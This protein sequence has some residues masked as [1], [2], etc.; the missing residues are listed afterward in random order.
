MIECSK[1][2]IEKPESEFYYDKSRNR[3]IKK[4]KKCHKVN[5]K[6]KINQGIVVT[7]KDY[8][9]QYRE[10]NKE[11]Y[12]QYRND[13]KEYHKIKSTEYY[14]NNTEHCKELAKKKIKRSD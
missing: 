1:C 8:S 9:R 12:K 5:Y 7:N 6:D 14:K 3:Y 2:E 10:N 13:H 4:C 11:Y